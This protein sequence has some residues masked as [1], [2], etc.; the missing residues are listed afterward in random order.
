[1]LDQTLIRDSQQLVIDVFR[2]F[3]PQLLEAFG[4]SLYT[5]K[6]NHSQVT[7][8]DVTVE[9]TLRDALKQSFPE[10]GYEGEETGHT[11]A[12]G[13]YWLVDPI[14]GTSGFIRGL[15]CSTNMAA[16]VVNDEVVAAVIYDFVRDELYAAQKGEGAHKDG[17]RLFVNTERRAGNLVIYSLTSKTFPL[18][19]EALRE[20]GMQT[21]LP[22]GAA[23]HAYT[24][25]ASGKIDGIAVLR[26][27][28]GE[29][30]NAAGVL[31]AE[32]AGAVLLP[33]DDFTGVHR[34]EFII[35]SPYV[36]ETIEHSGLI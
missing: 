26:S 16:L 14:D 31:I 35:G 30:D 33:Y 28:T 10:L 12:S 21:L 4:A 32:E 6:Q 1:M 24:L 20:I 15:E 2:R 34:S 5:R 3:R 8:W 23:G 11:G 13:A 27:K 25:L 18:V 19:S 29:Y 17:V 36:A 9:E 22:I 7:E